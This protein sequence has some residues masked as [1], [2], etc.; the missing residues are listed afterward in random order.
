QIL[1]DRQPLRG[2]EK[3]TVAVLVTLHLITGADP[4]PAVLIQLLLLV[5]IEVARTQR[6][7]QQVEVQRESLDDRVANLGIRM[8]R[9]P[10]LGA[11]L[12]DV[13]ADTGQGLFRRLRGHGFFSAFCSKIMMCCH[14]RTSLVWTCRS[15]CAAIS[16]S[17]CR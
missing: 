4:A 5:W 12:L 14:G 15:G 16:L 9:R 17:T 3:Q 6:F 2:G 11:V 7:A 8:G 13:G 1:G 10:R